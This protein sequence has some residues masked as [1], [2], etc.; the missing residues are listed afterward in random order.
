MEEQD[1]SDMAKSGLSPVM[2]NGFSCFDEDFSV[3]KDYQNTR[4]DSEHVH[5]IK[6]LKLIA[7]KG[8]A[9]YSN[10]YAGANTHDR[11]LRMVV[12]CFL[13]LV[14]VPL[15]RPKAEMPQLKRRLPFY[16]SETDQGNGVKKVEISENNVEI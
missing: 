4:E 6:L 13:K 3:L 15:K 10:G 11:E 9:N 14:L 2:P 5:D 16:N 8:D 12:L 1:D 7:V